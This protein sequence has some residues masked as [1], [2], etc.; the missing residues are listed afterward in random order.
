MFH[1]I[2]IYIYQH[3]LN[4]MILLCRA[5]VQFIL[6]FYS[7]T[8]VRW[9]YNKYINVY[10]LTKILYLFGGKLC[11]KTSLKAKQ[12]WTCQFV[13]FQINGSNTFRLGNQTRTRIG[14]TFTGNTVQT[15]VLFQVH[16]ETKFLKK[17]QKITAIYLKR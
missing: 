8:R 10:F 9:F 15:C 1:Y 13:C 16:K 4:T 6:Y 11:A 2:H 5:Q 7:N 14:T 17:Y 3:Y 12:K